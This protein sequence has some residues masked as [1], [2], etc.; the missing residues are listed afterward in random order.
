MG[1]ISYDKYY[2]PP[3]VAKFCYE[4]TLEIIGKENITE[5]IEPSAGCGSFSLLIP[6][7]K[8]YD[9]YPQ[10]KHIIKQNFL[11]LDLGGY[12][13]GRLFIGNP[14]YG[15]QSGKLITQF[16]NKCCND[17][18]YIAWILPV[19]YYNNYDFFKKFEI[20]YQKIITTKYSNVEMKTAFIIYK[21]NEDISNFDG[22]IE[23]E[24]IKFTRYS[25]S[26]KYN[27]NKN[28]ND[29]YYFTTFGTI[30]KQCK[31]YQYA[32]VHGVKINEKYRNKVI[33]FLKWLYYYNK[34]TNILNQ[35]SISSVNLNINRL[36]QL[37]K[38]AIPEIK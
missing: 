20:I 13:K 22:N 8:A 1:K 30:L 25:K 14:P 18:D 24:N 36:K 29:D 38:I 21:R 15:G 6:D 12:K 26:N 17:G 7:C 16:Y 37:I 27:V 19:G 28:E 5:I 3:T 33:L 35:F 34:E 9:L 32:A 2:T 10:A 4:K 31:P 23:F 11:D